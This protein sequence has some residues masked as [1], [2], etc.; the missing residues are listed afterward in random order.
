MKFRIILIIASAIAFTFSLSACKKEKLLTTGGELTFSVDTLSFDTVFT[1][2]ASFTTEFKI[3]NPQNQ[4]VNISSIRLEKGDNSFFKVNV[5]GIS[6]SNVQNMELAA[7]DSLYVFA[8]VNID[9]TNENN[10]FVVEDRMIITMNGK[11]YSVP[12]RAFGQNAYYIINQRLNTQTWKTDKPYVVVSSAQVD[13]NQ[14]LTIPAG[15][16]VYM[17]GDSRLFVFGT[18]KVLGTKTD[19]VLFRGDRLDRDYFANKDF[20]G[21]WGGLYFFSSSKDNVI[22]HAVIKNC[23]NGAFGA[24]PAAIQLDPNATLSMSNSV[25]YNSIGHGLLSFGGG[26]VMENCLIH[27][28]GAQALAVLQGGLFDINH[29]TFALHSIGGISGLKHVDNPAVAIQNFFKAGETVYAGSLLKGSRMRNSIIWGGIETELHC[30]KLNSNEVTFDLEI[31]NCIYKRK[32][33]LPT[34]IGIVENNNKRNEDPLFENYQSWNY[35]LKSGSP[36]INA[37]ISTDLTT[38]L[39]GKSRDANPDMGCY[40]FR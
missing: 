30:S 3:Y 12:F 20:A 28:C 11:E 39:D 21:E 18:L 1:Q 23:G 38:D 9:P 14:T 17:H 29:C 25:I 5:N 13:S 37:G 27:S 19:S 31:S 22:D 34:D 26:F 8:T 16:R 32:E 35:R 2:F 10:P 33:T 40:E 4:K 6:G 36:A 24:T 15:C 7:K